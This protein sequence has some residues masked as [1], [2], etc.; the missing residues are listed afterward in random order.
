MKDDYAFVLDF[1]VTGY[2][3]YRSETPIALVIGENHFNLLEV[4]IREDVTDVKPQDRLYI[5]SGERSVVK[6]IKGRISVDDLTATARSELNDIIE[7]IVMGDEQRFVNIYNKAGPITM[8]HHQL[9][10][11]PGIGK[12][13]M[14]EIIEKRKI[15]PFESF[16][17]IK[18]RVTLLPNPKKTIIKRI[19]EEVE[20]PDIKW[21]MFI[22][23]NKE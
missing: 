5:G 2:A 14:W 11:F 9:E 15:K 21:P 12:K 1:L 23:P 8:R 7:L 19:I 3:Q 18:A 17:D 16:A 22:L 13:H 6:S 10:L 4:T 20:N